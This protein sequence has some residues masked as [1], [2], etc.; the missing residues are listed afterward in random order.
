MPKFAYQAINENGNPVSGVI[1]ADSRN[2]ASNILNARGYIPRKIS[3]EGKTTGFFDKLD[4]ALTPIRAWDLILFSKQLGTMLRAGIP[5]LKLFQI[6]ES[7]TE[8]KKLKQIINAIIQDVEGG[9]SLHDSF[10]KHPAAFS[11]LYCSML[12]AG[13]TSGSLPEVLDRLTYIIEHEYKVKKDI[14]SAMAYPIIVV[15]AL[16]IAFLILLTYVV[17]KFVGIFTRVG[18]E[19]P[20]PTKVCM[21]MY[22]VLFNYWHFMLAGLIIAGV[23]L[24]LYFKTNQGKL[25]RDATLINVPLIGPLFI[26]SAMSRFASIFA[27]LQSSGV[28]VLEIIKIL[29][30][31]IGNAAIARV[32]DNLGDQLREGRGIAEPLR[33]AAYFT[34]M[35][36][37]MV[38]IGEESGN[39]DEMLSEVSKHYDIEVEYAT[40]RLSTAIGPILVVGLAAVVGFFALAI[41]LPMW[42]LT[43]MVR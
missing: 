10:K 24:Y 40:A 6:L 8:N 32:F 12:H 22:T 5:I 13:E 39:L 31:T 41:Y 34:P 17:P 36:V 14:Q 1:D 25:V 38:A 37:N 7:Q 16:F 4:A 30:G 15:V 18:I 2:A 9:S 35:V 23:A 20:W 29:S 26:K 33:S 21:V 42:D 19:I 27:I 43:K 11:P 28:A 3:E